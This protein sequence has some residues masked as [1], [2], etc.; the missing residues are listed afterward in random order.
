M[1]E[2]VKQSVSL[3]FSLGKSRRYDFFDSGNAAGASAPSSLLSWQRRPHAH[4]IPKYFA[5]HRYSALRSAA[6]DPFVKLILVVIEPAC[7]PIV[8]R[9]WLNLTIS[10]HYAVFPPIKQSPSGDTEICCRLILRQPNVITH[11][12]RLGFLFLFSLFPQYKNSFGDLS[13]ISQ[14]SSFVNNVH[15]HDRLLY[16]S[17]LMYQL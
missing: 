2:K 8:S 3:I 14:S 12:C 5:A 11:F 15:P 4:S 13:P 9:P 7:G 17:F 6:D 1:P 10:L 16:F